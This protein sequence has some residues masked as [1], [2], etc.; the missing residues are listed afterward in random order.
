MCEQMERAV[1]SLIQRHGEQNEA[2][3]S[4]RTLQASVAALKP[5]LLEYYLEC[6]I[7]EAARATEAL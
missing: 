1:Q 5:Q 3:T 7:E 6:R 4:A 2:V